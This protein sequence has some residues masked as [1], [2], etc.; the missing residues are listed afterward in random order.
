MPTLND[1]WIIDNSTKY[2]ECTS[3]LSLKMCRQRTMDKFYVCTN[4]KKYYVL[5]ISTGVQV[6]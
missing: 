5:A 4:E 3:I 2:D 6:R 1:Y